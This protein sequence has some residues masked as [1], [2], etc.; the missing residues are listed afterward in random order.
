MKA[1]YDGGRPLADPMCGSGSFALEAAMLAKQMAP[2]SRRGFAFTDW[3]AF[4]ERQWTFLK[5]QA[6]ASEQVLKRPRIFSSDIDGAACR[7]LSA[8][9]SENGLSDAVGV[10]TRDFFDC[11]GDQ[12]DVRP[13]LVAINPPYGIRI[14]SKNRAAELFAHIGSHL[15]AAFHGWDVALIA[16]HRDLV[17]TLPFA[18]RQMPLLHGGLRLTL[19]VGTIK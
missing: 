16:P 7:Q 9:I 13:G 4:S 17:E 15:K 3:P 14:G 18:V 12:Y 10:V 11:K 6:I 2:G 5:R 19:L 1:G 8:T